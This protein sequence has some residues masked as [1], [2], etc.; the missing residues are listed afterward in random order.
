M[1]VQ[2]SAHKKGHTHTHSHLPEHSGRY[3]Y[4]HARTYTHTDRRARERAHSPEAVSAFIL[5]ILQF[6]SLPSLVFPVFLSLSLSLQSAPLPSSPSLPWRLTPLL[7]LTTAQKRGIN[8]TFRLDLASPSFPGN[9]LRSRFRPFQAQCG[10]SERITAKISW[11]FSRYAE[12]PGPSRKRLT[13]VTSAL[14]QHAATSQ[15]GH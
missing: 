9:H 13:W 12:R 14:F 7:W 4:V 11:H 2:S 1:H 5:S 15:N 3:E 6:F 10:D 8:T